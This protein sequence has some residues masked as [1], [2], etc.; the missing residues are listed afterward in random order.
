[1]A[2]LYHLRDAELIEF[3]EHNQDFSILTE[4]FVN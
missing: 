2:K 3:W 4:N 1:M